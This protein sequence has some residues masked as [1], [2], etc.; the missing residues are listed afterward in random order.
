[1]YLYCRRGA[2]GRVPGSDDHRAAA[3]AGKRLGVGAGGLPE[4]GKQGSSCIPMTR[5]FVGVDAV[6][7]RMFEEDFARRLLH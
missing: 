5:R 4:G 6:R 1:M 7:R 2:S 3:H